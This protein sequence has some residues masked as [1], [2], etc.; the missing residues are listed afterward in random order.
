MGGSRISRILSQFGPER[1]EIL[2]KRLD[3]E[4]VP[5]CGLH[6]LVKLGARDEDFPRTRNCVFCKHWHKDIDSDTC[7]ECLSTL[8]LD[9]FS[10]QD[11]AKEDPRYQYMEKEDQEGVAL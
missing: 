3:V 5:R 10:V 1:R 7:L 2:R 8:H 6:E 11:D 4:Y 9:N